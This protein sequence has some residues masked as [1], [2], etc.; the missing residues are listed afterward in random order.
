MSVFVAG[1]SLAAIFLKQNGD[2]FAAAVM[3]LA[4]EMPSPTLWGHAVGSTVA[5]STNVF[6]K[7]FKGAQR[8]WW[9][10]TADAPGILLEEALAKIAEHPHPAVAMVWDLGQH[11]AVIVRGRMGRSPEEVVRDFR[12]ATIR[13]LTTLRE[14]LRPYRPGSLPVLFM[15]LGPVRAH[16]P[17]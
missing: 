3:A 14:R 11:E 17:I 6:P 16:P 2:E 4:P 7:P 12:Y 15:R 10:M 13:C 8:Y 9:D 5:A 1:Q